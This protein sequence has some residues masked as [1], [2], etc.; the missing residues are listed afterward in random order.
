MSK[1]PSNVTLHAGED[2]TL[3]LPSQAGAGYRWEATVDDDTVAE[4][5]AQFD[6]AVT[7]AGRTSFSR[8]ELVTLHGR[9]VGTTRVRCVQR[10]GWETDASPLAEHSITVNVVPAAAD[11]SVDKEGTNG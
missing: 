7:S 5:E 10:R 4:A 1:L 3:R 6:D 2:T 8:D 9:R 11:K